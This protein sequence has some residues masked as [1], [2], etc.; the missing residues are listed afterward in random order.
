MKAM[1]VVKKQRDR[2]EGKTFQ[3]EETEGSRMCLT[4]L[5]KA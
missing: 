3:A 1:K 4:G 5:F 2:L